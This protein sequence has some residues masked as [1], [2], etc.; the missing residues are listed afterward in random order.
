MSSK[1][2]MSHPSIA[3]SKVVFLAGRDPTEEIG[4]GHSSY[5]R[6]TAWAATALGLD[7]RIYC[8]SGRSG[9]HS[10]DYGLVRRVPHRGR[11]CRQT[12]VAFHAPALVDAA[13]EDF[14]PAAAPALI[15]S[16]GVWG[17]VGHGLRARWRAAGRVVPHLISMYTVYEEES[18]ALLRAAA[19]YGFLPY[20]R[21]WI[22]WRW[23]RSRITPLERAALLGADATAVN[24][25]SV[26][27]LLASYH[28]AGCRV[29]KIGY[30]PES[31][32]LS[33]SDHEQSSGSLAP[34]LVGEGPLIV[35]VT[36]QRPKKGVDKLLHALA[37]LSCCGIGF[38][39][40]IVGG[41]PLLSAHRRLAHDLRLS[42]RV[43]FTG[44]VPS[45][46]PYLEAADIFVLPSLR[47][48][49]GSLA[50]LE[51][52]QARCAI[53]ASGVDG[54]VEDVS[55]G[56]D[57]LLAKPGDVAGLSAAIASLLHDP[58]RRSRLGLA[59]RR[60]FER[61]FSAKSHLRELGRIYDRLG[62]P[63]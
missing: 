24:Y 15:H 57:G 35:A 4:G 26:C 17:H 10:C 3:A 48:E 25:E 54:I 52:M 7:V 45:V 49:S 56:Q 55:H 53:V 8:V 33:E 59:A 9:D 38:R 39:A 58:A 20:V 29:E 46:R 32:F 42:D 36:L 13:V 50:L 40:C 31:A 11:P 22:E 61:R 14:G 30:S 51:A 12:R 28:G 18:L 43:V 16:F 1:E 41:G 21:Q 19:S 2:A 37:R 34:G 62:V 60:T 44:L 47:E 6:A 63:T 23:I 5:V 27:T